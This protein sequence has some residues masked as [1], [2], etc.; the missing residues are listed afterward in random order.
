MSTPPSGPGRDRGPR[1]RCLLGQVGGMFAPR[2]ASER[3]HGLARGAPHDDVRLC[4]QPCVFELEGSPECW[5]NS[6]T[7]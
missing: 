5:H 4:S 2:G 7:A 6:R 1:W 3:V